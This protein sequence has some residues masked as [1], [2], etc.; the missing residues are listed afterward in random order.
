MQSF[1]VPFSPIVSSAQE[2]DDGTILIDSGVPGIFGVYDAQGDLI[3]QW[4]MSVMKNII[5]RV[6]QYD[7]KGF[8]FA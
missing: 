6:Y 4:K 3:S 2:L 7:F 5:Y 8:Y 1:K